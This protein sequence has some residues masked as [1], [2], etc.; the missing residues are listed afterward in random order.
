MWKT[1]REYSIT[2]LQLW[3]RWMMASGKHWL[4]V[5]LYRILWLF[6]SFYW[7]PSAY[8]TLGFILLILILLYLRN[9][10]HY[11]LFSV[12]KHTKSSKKF[13][14]N[15][16][17]SSWFNPVFLKPLSAYSSFGFCFVCLS[18]KNRVWI[19]KNQSHCYFTFPAPI[20]KCP[21]FSQIKAIS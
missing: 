8:E 2:V 10:F 17:C 4:G 14:S 6:W 9:S 20:L 16:I 19:K 15:L 21:S 13:H 11:K 18:G 1:T 7:S 12:H 5:F 3:T